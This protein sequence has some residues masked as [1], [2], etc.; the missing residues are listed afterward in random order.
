MVRKT[1]QRDVIL[2][3]LLGTASHPTADWIYEQVRKELPHISLG[4]VYRN[5]NLLK[6][7]GKILELD[8]AD[9]LSRFDGYAREHY[10]FRCERCGHIFDVD[11]PA[12]EEI[13][14]RVARSTGF[15]VSCH[16]L[17]FRGL[18]WD[19]QP[20]GTAEGIANSPRNTMQVGSGGQS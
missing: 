20:Q 2:R 5:L 14:K 18:C 15:T 13:D 4:T 17:E 6:L 3:V 8:L 7:E 11:E 19:C 10:H 12:D 16:R 1:K 9:S